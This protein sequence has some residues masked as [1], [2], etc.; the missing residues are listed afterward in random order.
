[1]C[2]EMAKD[3][4]SW[5]NLELVENIMRKNDN[6]IR[7]LNMFT[8]PATAKGD[9]YT[10]DMYRVSIEISCKRGDEEVTKKKSLVVKVA[11]TG[12]NIKKELI[13][14]SRIFHT[15]ISMMTDTLKKM[16]NLLGPAHLISGRVF[17]IQKEHPEF[18][19]MEDLAPLGFRMADRQAGLDLP[20]CLLA[21]RG[22]ARFHASS[23]AV[24][25]KEPNHKKFYTRGIFS[26][27]H[28]LEI[29]NFFILATKSLGMEM[30]K[31]PDLEKYAEK[32][33]KFAEKIYDKTAE[34]LKCR[35][36]EFN[37]INHGD[38]WVNNMMF[39]YN[40]EG[41]PIDHIFVDFQMCV[42]GSPANDLQYF[43]NTSAD[44]DVYEN[45]Q[46]MLLEEYLLTLSNMMKQ[47]DCKTIPL[48]MEKLRKNL[49]EREIL[50]MTSSFTIL[51]LVLL[52]KN[53]AKDLDE[54]M[55]KDGNEY[56]SSAF[57][58]E[59]YRKVISKRI[60]I[61]DQLGLMDL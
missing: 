22:L 4:P 9:N 33:D 54:I 12:E 16:N 37:V 38:F 13:E 19:V 21:I 3:T 36:D 11:P 58:N 46:D 41:K 60:P 17:Y 45:N 7:V 30:R 49:K 56:N 25:E 29:M 44:N 26:S 20:H 5:L 28:P 14:K 1:M 31:W 6:S 24:C 43:L 40:D 39:R 15:E 48:T 23:I 47:F 35:E 2:D 10:S 57:E 34:A 61:Y 50:A 42:Y 52:D 8:K 51:P 27:E 59:L 53:E 18:L 55:G 32:V